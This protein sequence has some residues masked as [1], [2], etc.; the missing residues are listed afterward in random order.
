[1]IQRLAASFLSENPSQATLPSRFMCVNKLANEL[2]GKLH[3]DEL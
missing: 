1:M 3:F 2:L